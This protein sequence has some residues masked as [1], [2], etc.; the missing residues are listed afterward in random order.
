MSIQEYKESLKDRIA[1]WHL[2]RKAM[3]ILGIALV[4][5]IAVAAF[6]IYYPYSDGTRTGYLRKL[7]HKGL[8]FKTWEGE[9]FMPGAVSPGDA[10]QVVTGG[11]LFMFSVRNGD[12]QVIK[13]LQDAEAHNTHPVTLHYKQYLKQFDWRGET[14]YFVDKVTKQQ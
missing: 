9:L 4:I 3:W 13:D 14:T 1:S 11:N 5:G 6:Y 12:D 2:F 10:S 7:S 8:A